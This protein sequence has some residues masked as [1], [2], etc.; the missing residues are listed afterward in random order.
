[1]WLEWQSDST[2]HTSNR[3]LEKIEAFGLLNINQVVA[4]AE[5]IL[6]EFD[7]FVETQCLLFVSRIERN[8]FALQKQL[9]VGVFVL[10]QHLLA[11]GWQHYSTADSQSHRGIK[12]GSIFKGS[13]AFHPLAKASGLHAQKCIK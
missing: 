2:S 10:K 3:N 7:F 9:K 6:F 13:G 1:M 8:I 12:I 11:F 5:R 4:K